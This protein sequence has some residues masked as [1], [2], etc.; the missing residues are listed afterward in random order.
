MRCI[1][2]DWAFKQWVPYAR[3]RAIVAPSEGMVDA[4]TLEGKSALTDLFRRKRA[5]LADLGSNHRILLLCVS[6]HG[7]LGGASTNS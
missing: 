2:A 3:S 5:P 4:R 7:S 1:N 6:F